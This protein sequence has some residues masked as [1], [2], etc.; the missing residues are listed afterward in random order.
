MKEAIIID[1]DGKYQEPTI[2]VNEQTGVTPIYAAI[3]PP[4]GDEE[5]SDPRITGYIVAERVPEGLYMPRWDLAAYDGYQEV[6]T[7]AQ[8]AYEEAYAAWSQQD[9]K[10]RGD[11]PTFV[12]PERPPFWIEGLTQEE[13]DAIH[14]T[15]QT[16][17]DAERIA[18]LEAQN[19]TLLMDAA[20]KSVQLNQQQQMISSLMTTV[21]QLQEGGAA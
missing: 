14:N 16:M 20:S 21:A 10:T 1:L 13:I 18:Q 17:S 4:E 9:V 8:V 5:P 3:E 19:A 7:A 12:P 11:A 2:V 6:L 15:P